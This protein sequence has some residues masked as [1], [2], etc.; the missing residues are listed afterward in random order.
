MTRPKFLRPPSCFAP[1]PTRPLH[2]WV[3]LDG[4]GTTEGE[5]RAHSQS[6]LNT[7]ITGTRHR[8]ISMSWRRADHHGDHIVDLN[9]LST[10]D[11]LGFILSIP[12]AAKIASYGFGYDLSKILEDLPPE[13]LFLL[14]HP[15]KRAY[16]CAGGKRKGYRPVIW[17]GFALDLFNTKFRVGRAELIE[18]PGQN[19]RY[20]MTNPRIIHDLS[21][22]YQAKFVTA[23]KNWD[24]GTP[25]ERDTMRAMK[26][27]RR[28][29]IRYSQQ[30]I[31]DYSNKECVWGAE[32]AQK[33]DDACEEIGVELR[34][35]YFGAGS[36]AKALMREWGIKQYMGV[37]PAEVACVARI[38]FFG[39]RFEISRRGKVEQPVHDWDISS[40]YP[41]QIFKLPCMACGTWT[42]T[43]DLERV[44]NAQAAL[45]NY[46]MNPWK[47]KLPPWGPF[48]FRDADGT[49]PFPIESGGGWVHKDEFLV[50][51]KLWPNVR[52]RG[53][54]VYETSCGHHPFAKVRDVYL[55]RL[56]I[57]KEGPG[58]V[59]KLGTNAIAGS[60]MQV[61]G[62]RPYHCPV[63]SGMITSG[64]RAQ[65]LEMLGQ[66]EKWS[67]VIMMATDGLWGLAEVTAPKPDETGTDIEVTE[68]KTGKK[69]RKP[70]GGWEHDVFESGVF[71]ARPGIYFPL[72]M[73]DV[74]T[75]ETEHDDGKLKD[76]KARG[77]GIR[78]LYQHRDALMV[79]YYASWFGACEPYIIGDENPIQVIQTRSVPQGVERF[80]GLKSG[81]IRN[82]QKDETGA[83]TGETFRKRDVYG[84]WTLQKRKIDFRA[85]P[86]RNEGDGTFLEVRRMPLTQ[87]SEEYDKMKSRMTLEDILAG[88][89][90]LGHFDD[91][92]DDFPDGG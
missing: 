62:T 50:G 26:A 53:A 56:R 45:V 46:K 55:E 74:P 20:K 38:A 54:W 19:P 6:N 35:Q 90:E 22:F 31:L 9:G 40:A 91:E 72:G 7:V 24:V 44:K 42:K 84:L 39:G 88:V 27:D 79:H 82:V 4:E 41:Y 83:M 30:E 87:T 16:K 81:V 47:G 18:L 89:T 76:L 66:H 33:L 14:T 67:D 23:C 25:K 11:C 71:M 78:T 43:T 80:V 1:E 92:Q 65:L 2:Y 70:L 21:K 13:L 77:I 60:I 10:K 64:T 49:I 28:N 52:F 57:G 3:M 51:M 17:E 58:I 12:E 5:P 32:L 69:T 29:L 61:I 75:E 34:G 59:L 86:K 63:W 15:D 73:A 48:P 36:I 37:L 8:Y 68:T 85:L